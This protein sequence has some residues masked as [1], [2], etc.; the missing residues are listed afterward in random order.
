MK[1]SEDR[2]ERPGRGATL[3]RAGTSRVPRARLETAGVAGATACSQTGEKRKKRFQMS[4]YQIPSAA[5][6]SGH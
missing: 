3:G 6:W 5:P 1:G 2:S 4:S